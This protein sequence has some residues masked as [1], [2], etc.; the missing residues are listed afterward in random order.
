MGCHGVEIFIEKIDLHQMTILINP[1]IIR[2]KK[3]RVES[4]CFIS[5]QFYNG[6]HT[7]LLNQWV[8]WNQNPFD[9]MLEAERVHLG[10]CG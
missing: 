5:L 1:V 6:I 3:P 8:M 9:N 10:C 4:G 7:M 2:I